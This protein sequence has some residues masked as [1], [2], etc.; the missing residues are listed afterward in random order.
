VVFLDRGTVYAEDRIEHLLAR[1][2]DPIID[3]FFG[4][5]EG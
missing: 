1:D 4:G 2:A 5:G 3:E